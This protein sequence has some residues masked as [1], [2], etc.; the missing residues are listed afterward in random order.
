MPQRAALPTWGD[1]LMLAFWVTFDRAGR[2]PAAT[3]QS[4][5]AA[6]R[7]HAD[8]CSSQYG[9]PVDQGRSHAE[10]SQRVRSQ[11]D[12]V[13]R[14]ASHQG[15][16]EAPRS[17]RTSHTTRSIQNCGPDVGISTGTSG[18]GAHRDRR[19]ASQIAASSA[20]SSPSVITDVEMVE[21]LRARL[22]ERQRVDLLNDANSQRK[23]IGK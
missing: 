17:A 1:R 8:R 20:D 3:L 12:P 22:G 4:D 23:D 6:K 5:L 18:Q 9:V 16:P 14:S 2:Q 13:S 19:N 10:R 21:V 15:H 7:E 11:D